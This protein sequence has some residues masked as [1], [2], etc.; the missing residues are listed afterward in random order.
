MLNV[1]TSF[2]LNGVLVPFF[3][4]SCKVRFLGF[5]CPEESSAVEKRVMR[6]QIFSRTS[7]TAVVAVLERISKIASD[8]K[9]GV[10]EGQE[11]DYFF[12]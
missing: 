2:F 7:L 9:G 4:L 11:T 5:L 6:S 12:S 1:P 8:E 10:D 3:S